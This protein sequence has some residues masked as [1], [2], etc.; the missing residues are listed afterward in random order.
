MAPIIP[1][2]TTTITVGNVGTTLGNATKNMGGFRGFG[3]SVPSSGAISMSQCQLIQYGVGYYNSWFTPTSSGNQGTYTSTGITNQAYITYSVWLAST[4]VYSNWRNLYHVT[5]G[6]SDG[7]RKPATWI[8][9]GDTG[10][11]VRQDTTGAGNDGIGE[12]SSRITMNGT[13]YNLTVVLN[14]TNMRAY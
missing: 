8:Y 9:A 2:T 7:S 12:T 4:E 14:G 6:G 5:D 10:F 13:V 1:S 11:H 3:G